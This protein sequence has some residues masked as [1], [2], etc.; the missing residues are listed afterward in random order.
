MLIVLSDS[1][2][3]LRHYQGLPQLLL[4]LS[5][6]FFVKSYLEESEILQK[7]LN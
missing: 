4:R 2:N 1:I 5:L 6:E 3:E 7:Y